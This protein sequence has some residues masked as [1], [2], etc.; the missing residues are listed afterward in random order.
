MKC[1]KCKLD[2]PD[3]QRFCGE[4]GTQLIPSDKAPAMPTKTLETPRKE[5]IRGTI[6]ASRYEVIEELG[7]GGMGRVYR[8]EDKKINE[9]VALKLISPEVASDKETIERFSNELKMARKISHRNV[10]R[11]YDLGEVEGAHYI[12]MEYVAGEDLKSFIRRSRQLTVGT[13]ISI[14]KQVCEG[15]S[16]AHRLG[17]LHRDL[18]PKNIMIDKEGN[19]RIMDFGIARSLK[20]RGITGAGVMIGTPEY[21]SP[22]QVDG[23]DTDQRSDIYSLGII[24]YEMVTGKIPFEGETP[25][26]VAVKQKSEAPQEPKKFNSQI[27]DDL[28]QL[29]LK[30]IKKNNE[31]R[32]QSAEELLSELINIESG[33]PMTERIIPRRK[34][35]TSREITVTFGLKKLFIPALVVIAA[36]IIGLVIW[37]LLQEKAAP[38]P[39]DKPSLAI[40]YFKNNTGDENLDHL[41]MMIPDLLI[42]DLNQS[43]HIRMLSAERL[44]EILRKLNLHEEKTYSSGDLKEVAERGRVNHVLVGNYAKAGDT[45]RIN[46]TLQKASTGETIGSESVEGR[47]EEGIFPMVDELTKRIKADFKISSREIASD[48]DEAIGKITTNSHEAY[49]YYSEGRKCHN[50]GD[51]RNSIKFMEKATAVDPEFAMAYRSMA[52]SYGNIGLLSERERY[53]QKALDLTDRLSDRERFLIQGDFYRMSEDTYDK[54][55]EAYDKLFELYP[56]DGTGINNSSIIYIA[57]EKW[58][59]AIERLEINRQNRHVSVQSYTN[60]AGPYQ[61]KGL[62][63]MAREVLKDYINSFSDTASIRCHLADTYINQ[64]KYD[65]ALAEVNMA[66]SISPNYFL[67]F[68]TRGDIYLYRGDFVCAE[69]E[70]QKLLEAGN[71]FG[72]FMNKVRL[73]ELYLLKGEFE[74]SKKLARQGI[75]LSKMVRIK[76]GEVWFLLFLAH[77]HETLGD[78][79]DALNETDK[80]WNLAVEEKSPSAQI[81]I[82]WEKGLIY[83]RMNLMN[84]AQEVADNLKELIKKGMNRKMI[85]LYNHLQG[86]IEAAKEN[87]SEAIDYFR[88]AFA[89]VP[90]QYEM[91]G[92]AHAYFIAP[93]ASAYYKSGDLNKAIK[94]YE[95]IASFNSGRI[96]LGGLYVKCFYMLG[97]LYQKKGERGKAAENYQKFLDHWKDA[98]SDLP[99]IE[100]AKIQLA[101]LQTQ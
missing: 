97:K 42:A 82:L 100:D 22:E 93:L 50:K 52:A 77:V 45:F 23:K 61:A 79:E 70:Y 11:M 25:L 99:E 4:C 56:D 46:V 36:V 16:E 59:K 65:L 7:K 101:A 83:V 76:M 58:D 81:L 15:L 5:L 55:L 28:N 68:L 47:G 54:A 30:C 24:L 3:T 20:Q 98:D 12:T 44:F 43:K 73:S 80:A 90:S 31:M 32:Y 17:I 13:S 69:E 85:R 14:A 33:I 86:M 34:P 37:Q 39:L 18:K 64:G 78:F 84:K 38:I 35:L 63:D 8:V 49:K 92:S 96:A 71:P 75:A 88:K 10:C 72:I 62:Y 51:Y 1:P 9:E 57:L 94:E 6:F 26:S 66:F 60:L 91:M 95:R 2:N 87:Y 53:I 67:N 21:M 19:A 40:M 74:K 29:I 27:P 41:S 89:L 48:I